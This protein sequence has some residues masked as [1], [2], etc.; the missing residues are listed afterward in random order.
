[1]DFMGAAESTFFRSMASI[2]IAFANGSPP[3]VAVEQARRGINS[4]C[5]PNR[6]Q[7]D[8]LFREAEAA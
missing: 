5:R 1:M 3:K 2:I 8:E 7:L 6:A 4:D